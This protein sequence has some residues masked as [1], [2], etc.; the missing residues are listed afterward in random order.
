MPPHPKQK[1]CQE[2]LSINWQTTVFFPKTNVYSKFFRKKKS[3]INVT[4]R[5]INKTIRR[6]F[7][8]DT[9]QR[10]KGF[11]CLLFRPDG[12]IISW[13]QSTEKVSTTPKMSSFIISFYFHYAGRLNNRR[14]LIRVETVAETV[15]QRTNGSIYK[16]TFPF[17]MPRFVIA[18]I[19]R[20]AIIR[21]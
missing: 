5:Y 7:F 11:C 12:F 2:K 15:E 13:N 1:E 8:Q 4:R 18:C 9:Y 17:F 14:A 3:T 20:N 19:T 6:V 21:N 16:P 10:N